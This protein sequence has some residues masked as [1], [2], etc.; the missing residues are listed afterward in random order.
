MIEQLAA[1]ET[2]QDYYYR[3]D[4]ETAQ[5]RLL[6]EEG[7]EQGEGVVA[8]SSVEGEEDGHRQGIHHPGR[9]PRVHGS[10]SSV[11]T[12]FTR[13]EKMT[14]GVIAVIA[15][16]NVCVCVPLHYHFAGQDN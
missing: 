16:L 1:E 15:F 12:G 8:S 4:L 7:G 10:T 2:D 11:S 13:G 5:Q 9:K 6:P 3:G 14:F